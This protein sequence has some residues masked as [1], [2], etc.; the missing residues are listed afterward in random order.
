VTIYQNNR[1]DTKEMETLYT[2]DGEKVYVPKKLIVETLNGSNNIVLA[3]RGTNPEKLAYNVIP[4]NKVTAEHICVM[5]MEGK[6]L[7]EIS[8][9]NTMPNLRTIYRWANK[10]EDFAE[11]M[12][13]ARVFRA[14][15]Y[16]DS[17][18]E[19]AL[20][21]TIETKDDIAKANMK[22]GAFKWSAEKGDPDRFGSK[23]ESKGSA[24]TTIIVNTGVNR[25]VEDKDTITIKG[26]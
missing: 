26:K 22:I 6:T 5:I 7:K 13:K 9:M 11:N 8:A 21:E 4:F 16:A 10:N 20:D 2:K 15:F 24:P 3:V 1:L 23:G 17:V 25:D 14:E 12:N 18:L 19:T